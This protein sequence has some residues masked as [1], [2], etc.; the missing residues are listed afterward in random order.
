MQDC[1]TTTQLAG[2]LVEL[3]TPEAAGGPVTETPV[4]IAPSAPPTPYP[5]EMSAGPTHRTGSR[6]REQRPTHPR[7]CPDMAGQGLSLL[8]AQPYPE[9]PH[10]PHPQPHAVDDSNPGNTMNRRMHA[11]NGRPHTP[12]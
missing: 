8:F 4:S 3:V 10:G 12:T 11:Q 9:P 2:P 1:N 7:P 6:V 5:Q